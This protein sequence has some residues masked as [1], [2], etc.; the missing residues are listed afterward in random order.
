[1]LNSIA[2]RY[3]VLTH[4]TGIYDTMSQ[5]LRIIEFYD[6]RQNYIELGNNMRMGLRIEKDGRDCGKCKQFLSWDN[7]S[8]N[9]QNSTGYQSRCKVCTSKNGAKYVPRGARKEDTE[10]EKG[11]SEMAQMFCLGIKNALKIRGLNTTGKLEDLSISNNLS[12]V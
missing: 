12:F 2:M 10:P 4:N 1:M 3:L 11:F 9:K 8:K 5:N 7:F 6:I